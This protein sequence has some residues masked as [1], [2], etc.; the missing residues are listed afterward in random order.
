M[1]IYIY[2]CMYILVSNEDIVM[3]EP[4]IHLLSSY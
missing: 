4:D 3:Y 1:Y 2:I